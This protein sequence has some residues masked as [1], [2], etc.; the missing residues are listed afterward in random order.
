MANLPTS[1]AA[2]WPAVPP[3]C[4]RRTLTW[5][6][7]VCLRAVDIHAKQNKAQEHPWSLKQG[8]K[9]PNKVVSL[10][11]P[12]R[13]PHVLVRKYFRPKA[14]SYMVGRGF[15]ILH[16]WDCLSQQFF[17]GITWLNIFLPSGRCIPLRQC[18]DQCLLYCKCSV[19]VSWLKKGKNERMNEW[20]SE[21]LIRV[22]I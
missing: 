7:V 15:E 4:S 1:P 17:I 6:V 10:A 20:S 21:P 9:F 3:S 18:P 16:A 13:S 12:V 5:K 14:H 22:W 11:Q 19:N 8:K 2:I